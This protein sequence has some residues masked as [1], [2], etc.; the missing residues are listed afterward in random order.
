MAQ[1]KWLTWEYVELSGSHANTHRLDHSEWQPAGRYTCEAMD[2][3]K[4]NIYVGN[5][6]ICHGAGSSYRLTHTHDDVLGHKFFKSVSK[7]NYHLVFRRVRSKKVHVSIESMTEDSAVVVVSDY[8]VTGGDYQFKINARLDESMAKLR[9]RILGK[10]RD[11]DAISRASAVT[12]DEPYN[13]QQHI[14]NCLIRPP[15]IPAVSS[16]SC[17][18]RAKQVRKSVLKNAAQKRGDSSAVPLDDV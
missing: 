18:G 2:S 6:S 15:M 1:A 8:S 16:A 4:S 10:F 9:D 11:L 7:S 5:L 3:G 17:K 12:F 13:M 14:C